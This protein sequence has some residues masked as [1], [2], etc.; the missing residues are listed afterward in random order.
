[1]INMSKIGVLY[2]TLICLILAAII[3]IRY[4][5]YLRVKI[6][7]PEKK[8]SSFTNRPN[9]IDLFPMQIR[10]KPENEI[11]NRKRAN[12]VLGIFYLSALLSLIIAFLIQNYYGVNHE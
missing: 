4:K 7:D 8:S 3:S 11:K 10:Y 5:V 6:T 9:L 1:M 2:F 12:I